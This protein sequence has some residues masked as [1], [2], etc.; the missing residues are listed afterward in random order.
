MRLL[1]VQLRPGLIAAAALIFLAATPCCA[2]AGADQAALPPAE[3]KHAVPRSSK[4]IFRDSDGSLIT[5]N[6][7]VDIRM[8]NPTYP[9]AT[10][11]RTLDD[12]TVEFRLQKVPQEGMDAPAI[13]L[14]TLDGR[15]VASS[16]LRGKVLVLN[17]WF[18]GCPP[19]MSE[20]PRLNE[21]AGKFRSNENVV[22]VAMT[23]DAAHAVKKFIGQKPFDY[24]M[25]ADARANMSKFVFSGYPKNIVVGKDGRIV[26]WRSTVHAWDKFESVIRAE[27]GK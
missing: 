19:C 10:I 8:A 12:G 1:W 15:S 3:Q 9:D 4:T 26:Y 18:I 6:E 16:D 17:F 14:K 13:S 24:L 22:F 5:N 2:Q 20:I 27:L 7:F 11:V 25:A 21:L 23:D